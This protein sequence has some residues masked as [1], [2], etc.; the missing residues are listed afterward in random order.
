MSGD[1]AYTHDRASWYV[2]ALA[3]EEGGGGITEEEG[4]DGLKGGT[5][6]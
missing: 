5:E 4:L 6:A 2:K 3:E 1:N